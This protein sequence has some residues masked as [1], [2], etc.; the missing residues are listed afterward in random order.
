MPRWVVSNTTFFILIVAISVVLLIPTAGRHLY[1][2]HYRE[3][4]TQ[5]AKEHDFKPAYIAALIYVESKFASQAVSQKGARGLMQIMPGTGVWIAG[6]LEWD[7]FDEELLYDP[8]INITMGVWYLANLRK[9]FGDDVAAL[10]AYN[11]GRGN[12]RRWLENG[13]WSGEMEDIEGIPF[14]ETRMYLEK[15]AIIY[16]RYQWLYRP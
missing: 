10:A 7:G 8:E 3:Y 6:E 13:I 15:H 9:E 5:K 1:P 2:F 4:I 11:A 14:R 16:Q 12:V